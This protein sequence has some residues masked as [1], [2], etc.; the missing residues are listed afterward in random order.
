MKARSGEHYEQSYNAQAAVEVHSRLVV[1]QMVSDAPNDRERLVP[2]LA[3]QSPVLGSARCWWT[4]GTIARRSSR[5]WKV[6]METGRARAQGV[7]G[8]QTPEA[9][10]QRAGSGKA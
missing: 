3:T 10:A 6:P 9:W 5:R 1:G 8:H 2:T 4:A 7:C